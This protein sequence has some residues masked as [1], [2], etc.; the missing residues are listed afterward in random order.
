LAGRSDLSEAECTELLIRIF[1]H[2][3]TIGME[4]KRPEVGSGYC[5]KPVYYSM[6]KGSLCTFAW[7]PPVYV[8]GCT[9]SALPVLFP[10]YCSTVSGRPKCTAFLP[11]SHTSCRW[12][13]LLLRAVHPAGTQQRHPHPVPCSRWPSQPL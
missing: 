3:R 6:L 11:C 1:E 13:V 7:L 4:R 5:W 12:F 2:L 8:P 10:L 9:H